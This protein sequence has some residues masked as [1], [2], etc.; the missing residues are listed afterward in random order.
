M[1]MINF[2]SS[3][4]RKPLHKLNERYRRKI[5]L[6][7]RRNLH[8]SIPSSPNRNRKN[9]S[10]HTQDMPSVA[11]P[12]EFPFHDGFVNNVVDDGFLSSSSY[13]S[14]DSNVPLVC[15]NTSNESF[16]RMQLA[17]C[18]VDNNLTHVQGNNILA[19][20]RKHKCFSNLPKDVRTVISTPR[21]RVVVSNVEPGE[22]VHFDLAKSIIQIISNISFANSIN[23]LELDLHIRMDAA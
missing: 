10:V 6:E 3:T 11:H 7:V 14:D 23:E 19:L 22:Y 18:F 8:Q 13:S 17:S 1:E 4:S 20:L 5:M 21:K 15:E 12:L 9:N 16:S 2:K